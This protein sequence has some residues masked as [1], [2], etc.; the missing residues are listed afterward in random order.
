MR[1][2]VTVV[3]TI[4]IV[5]VVSRSYYGSCV[6]ST[7]GGATPFVV[8]LIVI[9][10]SVICIANKQAFQA[11]KIKTE[12]AESRYIG[13]MLQSWMVGLPI[14]ALIQDD[15]QAYFVVLT[16][17]MFATCMATLLFLFIPKMTWQ[18]E[19]DSSHRGSESANQ[20]SSSTILR[21][22]ATSIREAQAS[23]AAP[24]SETI[25]EGVE[26]KG[27]NEATSDSTEPNSKEFGVKMEPTKS[28]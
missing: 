11:R 24:V 8:C 25:D 5:W 22:P 14:L 13:T 21:L 19:R 3:L 7:E 28:L 10:F 26:V 1:D 15:P 23:N 9:N 4:G 16:M 27:D 6:G 20:R 17:I 2:V 18:A 12:F